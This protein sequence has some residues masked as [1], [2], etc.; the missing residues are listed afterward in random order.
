ME[1]KTTEVD[2][3]DGID[4]DSYDLPDP[5]RAAERVGEFLSWYGDGRLYPCVLPGTEDEMP[6]LFARDLEAL[7]KCADSSAATQTAEQARQAVVDDFLA[8]REQVITAI[9]NCHPDNLADYYRWQ[10]HA[11]ARRHLSERLAADLAAMEAA[12]KGRR[13]VDVHLPESTGDEV[14]G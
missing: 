13:V 1:Q 10:G 5:A 3:P 11:E 2:Q 6:P 14:T 12:P 7:R 8:E 4:G 9:N